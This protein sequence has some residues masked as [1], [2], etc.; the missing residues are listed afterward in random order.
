MKLRFFKPK[1]EIL[2]ENSLEKSECNQVITITNQITL[3]KSIEKLNQW[4]SINLNE[5]VFNEELKVKKFK[6]PQV[7]NNN[8]VKLI[9]N[10]LAGLDIEKTSFSPN[11]LMP[12]EIFNKIKVCNHINLFKSETFTELGIV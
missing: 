11:C 8:A 4:I 7:D 12:S 2:I 5:K 1:I 10:D 6:K 3:F 9:E